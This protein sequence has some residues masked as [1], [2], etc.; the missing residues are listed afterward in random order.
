MPNLKPGGADG[1]NTALIVSLSGGGSG[2]G[3]GG[4]K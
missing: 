1:G 2:I 3:S 4:E